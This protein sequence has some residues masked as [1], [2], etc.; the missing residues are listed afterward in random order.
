MTAWQIASL[1]QAFIDRCEPHCT[2]WVQA[3]ASLWGMSSSHDLD[4]PVCLSDEVPVRLRWDG[5]VTVA[6]RPLSL[7]TTRAATHIAIRYYFKN[8]EFI[9][10]DL[11]GV[12]HLNFGETANIDWRPL[13]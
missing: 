7:T 2:A 12:P 8:G 3:T 11:I 4:E 9:E 13:T 5:D 6:D 1:P 10:A